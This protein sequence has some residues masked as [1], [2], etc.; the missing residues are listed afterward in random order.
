[1]MEERNM[2]TSRKE[3]EVILKEI[4]DETMHSEPKFSISPYGSRGK[5]YLY[6][7]EIQKNNG[8]I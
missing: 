1:M 3:I 4:F 2:K 5:K 8:G 6:L 7:Y